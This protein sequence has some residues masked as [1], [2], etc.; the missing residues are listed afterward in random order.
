M[1]VIGFTYFF[2]IMASPL[3]SAWQAG[4]APIPGQTVA[5][6]GFNVNT[7][8]RNQVMA[9]WHT[10]Y[11]ASEGYE[12]RID[13]TGNYTGNPGTVSSAFSVDIERR[14]NYFRAMAG[15]PANARVNSGATVRIDATD[16]HQPSPTETKQSAAQ[17]MAL[18]LARNH[19]SATG[20]NPAMSHDP[21]PDLVGWSAAAWNGALRGSLGVGLY[22]PGAITQYMVENLPKDATTSA[23]NKFVGHRRLNLRARSTDYG[24]GDQPGSGLSMLATNVL[25]VVQNAG[26]SA[27][28]VPINF[29]CYPNAGFFPAPLNTRFW[30]ASRS[31]AVFTNATVTMN[32]LDGTSVPI[33]NVNRNSSYAEPA[34]IWEVD[35]ATAE[36]DISQDVTYQVSITGMSGPGIPPNYQYEVTL[37]NPS[38]ITANQTLRGSRTASL[39]ADTPYQWVRPVDA[40]AVDIMALETEPA[41]WVEN[42]ETPSTAQ[43]ID[44]T[45]PNYALIPAAGAYP[46]YSN[47]AGIRS[48]RLTFGSLYD[49]ISRGVREEIFMINREILTGQSPRFRFQY[50]RG[51]MTTTSHLAIE[52]SDNQGG[53]WQ[54]LGPVISGI[55]NNQPGSGTFTFDQALPP[56][57]N[58]LLLRFRLYRS[59]GAIYTQADHPSL[60][61]GIFVDQIQV[62][63]CDSP[64]VSRYHRDPPAGLPFIF[65]SQTAGKPLLRGDQWFLRMRTMLGG[66]W[67]YGPLRSVTIE[68]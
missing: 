61:T 6:L 60:P 59:G 40:E 10:V 65:N 19:N 28:N 44:L 26:E 58:P 24:S 30:S 9:F 27:T 38:I 29:I 1:K 20:Q 39:R 45:S 52:Y 16:A 22:G 53:T 11:L 7:Q 18:M 37:I 43:I 23:W 41:T 12:N 47:F 31:G 8:S 66:R 34:L 56:S 57:R 25:Y 36:T 63:N 54:A 50:R 49:S 15:V 62:T 33:I 5:S 13:W 35:A 2:T 46:G 67:F 3:L 64:V 17:K 55:S 21:S 51:Y 42:A 68:N 4:V 48:F 14:L 32:R